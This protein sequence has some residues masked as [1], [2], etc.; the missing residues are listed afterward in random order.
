M[1]R[2]GNKAKATTGGKQ[3][4]ITPTPV[5]RNQSN[6]S[7]MP[8]S[9]AQIASGHHVQNSSVEPTTA[10]TEVPHSTVAPETSSATT[11]SI[12][13][14]ASGPPQ[15]N[16][17]TTPPQATTRQRGWKRFRSGSTN[18]AQSNQ[19]P[20]FDIDIEIQAEWENDRAQG[21]THDKDPFFAEL[22][23]LAPNSIAE[24]DDNAASDRVNE[25]VKKV[26]EHFNEEQVGTAYTT[27][28][29]EELEKQLSNESGQS[30]KFSNVEH[31]VSEVKDY[32]PETH[33]FRIQWKDS[34]E[35][36]S[37]IATLDWC[38]VFA[39]LKANNISPPII[40]LAYKEW[41]QAREAAGIEKSLG[42][43]KKYPISPIAGF[44]ESCRRLKYFD[45]HKI[46]QNAIQTFQVYQQRTIETLSQQFLS[47]DKRY[48]ETQFLNTVNQIIKI[49]EDQ[50]A[51]V[52]THPRPRLLDLELRSQA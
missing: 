36:A 40:K 9:S 50:E 41:K 28:V 48:K 22:F 33:L 31:P 32:N 43:V 20:Q 34:L 10:H 27:F 46:P 7:K 11:N 47:R 15:P 35:Y 38:F 29:P 42:F 14:V 26:V 8:N 24:I 16:A 44:F 52:V 30:R 4:Q 1:A 49:I 17:E 39:S 51:S 37:S 45:P 5:P 25:F 3:P 13:I 23:A 2:T 19:L 12:N 21:S 18:E 6:S